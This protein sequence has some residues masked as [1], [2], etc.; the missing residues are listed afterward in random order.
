MT[1][2]FGE[3]APRIAPNADVDPLASVGGETVV[4][5]FAQIREYTRVGTGCSIGRGA[6]IGSSVLIGRN[7]TIGPLAVIHEP[8]LVEDGV[9]VGA[10]AV[11]LRSS[12]PRDVD[13][14]S[15]LHDEQ[16]AGVTVRTGASI[17][18]NA[19]CVAPATIG[20]WAIVAPG[21]VVTD[22]VPDHAVVAGVPAKQ[23]GWVGRSGHELVPQG[24]GTWLCPVTGERYAEHDGVMSLLAAP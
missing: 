15:G 12:R 21:A 19:V 7:C 1:S 2:A 5:A 16:L 13:T 9:V 23:V 8:A 17:G 14:G 3:S 4:S 18:A 11:L 24:D 6:V 22:D 20:R 10:C